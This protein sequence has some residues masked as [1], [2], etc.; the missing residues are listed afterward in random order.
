MWG[1]KMYSVLVGRTEQQ[2][3]KNDNK[4]HY[5]AVECEGVDRIQ[6]FNV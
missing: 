6:L 2:G 4:T 5:K 1:E 3:S